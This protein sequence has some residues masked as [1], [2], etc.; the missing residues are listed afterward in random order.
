MCVCF[1]FENHLSGWGY[2]Q[3]FAEP[4]LNPSRPSGSHQ[5]LGTVWGTTLAAS[6]K[7]HLIICSQRRKTGPTKRRGCQWG[8]ASRILPALLFSFG[9]PTPK[10]SQSQFNEITQKKKSKGLFPGRCWVFV[11]WRVAC[12][13]LEFALFPSPEAAA[14]HGVLGKSTIHGQAQQPIVV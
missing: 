13:M 6:W 14:P 10:I 1:H 9:I 7:G 5:S 4:S 3:T 2:P 8:V 12:H 11:G